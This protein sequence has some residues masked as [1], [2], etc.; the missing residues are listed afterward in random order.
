MKDIVSL[1]NHLFDALNRLA[2]ASPEELESEITKAAAIV[3]V[4]E[5]IIKS[6]EVENQFIAITKTFGSGFVPV[7][8]EK[9]SLLKL[10]SDKAKVKEEQEGGSDEIFDV[11]KE[12][13]WLADDNGK[14]TEL[15]D[16][17]M[18]EGGFGKLA[19]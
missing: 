7:I 2:D 8:N 13:N 19:D 5:T 18:P 6:A 3:Q 9:A 14:V 1:R 17:D 4:S 15:G 16:H 10:V 12:K 11:D